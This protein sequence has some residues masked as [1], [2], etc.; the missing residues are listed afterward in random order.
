MVVESQ[1]VSTLP[2][3]FQTKLVLIYFGNLG[4]DIDFFFLFLQNLELEFV[5]LVNKFVFIAH[6]FNI[7]QDGV[8]KFIWGVS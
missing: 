2:L 4:S 7:V 5:L 8:K 6:L 3:H 1:T